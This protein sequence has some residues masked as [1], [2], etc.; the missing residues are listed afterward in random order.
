[1][2]MPCGAEP[3]RRDTGKVSRIRRAA[4]T[5]C[6]SPQII[7]HARMRRALMLYISGRLLEKLLTFVNL[8]LWHF[9]LR[10]WQLS[11]LLVN[12]QTVLP[13]AGR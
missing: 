4:F 10:I 2:L 6:A 12:C 8:I 1:M 3:T 5:P 9:V 13:A 11:M 7:V